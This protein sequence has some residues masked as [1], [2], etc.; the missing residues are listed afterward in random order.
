MSSEELAAL[1][2]PM[3]WVSNSFCLRQLNKLF[4]CV[5]AGRLLHFALHCHVTDGRCLHFSLLFLW[6]LDVLYEENEGLRDLIQEKEDCIE[7]LQAQ[8]ERLLAEVCPCNRGYYL[9]RLVHMSACALFP[10]LHTPSPV[11]KMPPS[12]IFVVVYVREGNRKAM[13]H[14]HGNV[15]IAGLSI[16]IGSLHVMNMRKLCSFSASWCSLCRCPSSGGEMTPHKG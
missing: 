4:C 14:L 3:Y 7:E 6:Q 13:E 12:T 10:L 11:S 1:A 5:T 15:W 2:N 9:P 16:K 8:V